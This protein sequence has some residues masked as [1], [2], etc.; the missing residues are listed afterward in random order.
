MKTYVSYYRISTKHQVNE[1]NISLGIEGQ[2]TAVKSYIGTNGIL[3]HEFTEIES[4]KN[5]NRPILAKAI[6]AAK[7]TN[8]CLIIAKLDRLSRE[9]SFLFELRNQIQQSGIDIKSLDMPDMSTL[10]LGIYGTI[11]QH[12]RETISKR[13]TV[14]LAELKKQ[15][16]TLGKPEN[17]SEESRAIGRSKM[18]ANS[19]NNDRNRQAQAM[20]VSL[21]GNGYSFKKIA[22]KLNELNFKTRR[23]NSFTS[24]GVKILWDRHIAKN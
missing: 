11:A 19:R 9:V 4:G 17:F 12:E 14:A 24:M 1:Q 15:G 13:T 23:N 21:R 18:I 2:K 5:N 20:V 10:N 6:E 22:D 7:K 16:V 3:V 8:S